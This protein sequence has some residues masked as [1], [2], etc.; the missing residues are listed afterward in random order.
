MYLIEIKQMS[1]ILETFIIKKR[2]S[3]SKHS[4]IQKFWSK[5]YIQLWRN[6]D[7]TKTWSQF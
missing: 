2:K 6:W 4:N 1:Q 3:K 7:I 5:N